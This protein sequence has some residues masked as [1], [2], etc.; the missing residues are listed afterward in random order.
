MLLLIFNGKLDYL[1]VFFN[2]F[3]L[4]RTTMAL[5]CEFIFMNSFLAAAVSEAQIKHPVS[6]APLRPPDGKL[7]L[8]HTVLRSLRLLPLSTLQHHLS[9]LEDEPLVPEE[10]LGGA[11]THRH[12]HS[13]YKMV[14]KK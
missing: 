10:D 12:V 4:P 11:P 3:S 5:S 8:S 2:L 6:R 7:L 14:K 1:T 13:L 9:L